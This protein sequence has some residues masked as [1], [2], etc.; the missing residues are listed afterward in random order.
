MSN[1][2]YIARLN[3]GAKGDGSLSQMTVGVFS[4]RKLAEQSMENFIE[5]TLEMEYP[6]I[7]VMARIVDEFLLDQPIDKSPLLI[8]KIPMKYRFRP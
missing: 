6:N 7:K 2:V 4:T 3:F 5:G 1:Q 8:L